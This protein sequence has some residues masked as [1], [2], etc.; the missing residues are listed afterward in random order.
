MYGDKGTLKL[1]V[2]RYDFTP[3]GKK[4]PTQSGEALFELDKYPEDKT[5]KDL[6]QH[7]AAANRRHQQ[8]FLKAIESR[9]RPVRR[10]GRARTGT[11]RWAPGT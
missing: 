9:G 3:A 4:E 11:G 5:E 10:L 1:S 8:D 2:H 6:E 7:V